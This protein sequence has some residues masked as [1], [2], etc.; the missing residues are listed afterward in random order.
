MPM[1]LKTKFLAIALLMTT[2]AMGQG[3]DRPGKNMSP[4]EIAQKRSETLKAKLKLSDAQYSQV[5]D[6]ILSNEKQIRTQREAMKKMRDENDAKMKSILTPE[7]YTQL[8]ELQAQRKEMMKNQRNKNE[9]QPTDN[10]P[11]EVK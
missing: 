11:S 5:Y 7:Q 2:I 8:K 6:Q 4:E 10:S 3:H 9:D 1:K